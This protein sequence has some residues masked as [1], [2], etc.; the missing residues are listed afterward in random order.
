MQLAAKNLYEGRTSWLCISSKN[1]T[2]LPPPPPPHVIIY[3]LMSLFV[4][5][6]PKIKEEK[7]IVKG[8]NGKDKRNMIMLMTIM[9]LMIE[10][11]IM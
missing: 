4:A 3:F 7:K 6:P 8:E 1:Y 10:T 5:F 9:V 11:I 2:D